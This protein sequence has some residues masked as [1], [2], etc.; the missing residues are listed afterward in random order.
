[1]SE[2]MGL[3]NQ[4]GG[5]GNLIK[6]DPI[7]YSLLLYRFRLHENYKKKKTNSKNFYFFSILF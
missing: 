5:G 3:Q 7:N 4:E 6:T 2:R 1:M